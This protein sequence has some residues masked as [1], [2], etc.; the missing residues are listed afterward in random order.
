MPG[1]LQHAAEEA[2]RRLGGQA[3]TREIADELTRNGHKVTTSNVTNTLKQL[4][5]RGLVDEDGFEEEREGPGR[6]ARRFRL[7]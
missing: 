5:E 3:T 2:L 4:A 1:K 6:P 7:W